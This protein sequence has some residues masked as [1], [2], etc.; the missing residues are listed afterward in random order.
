MSELFES[1]FDIEGL[2]MSNG[3]EQKM[4]KK[5]SFGKSAHFNK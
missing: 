1:V 2:N 3:G 4:Q 5:N